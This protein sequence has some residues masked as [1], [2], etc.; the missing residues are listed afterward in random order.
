MKRWTIVVVIGLMAITQ[1]GSSLS[2]Q[3]P[4]R[5]F[6]VLLCVAEKAGDGPGNSQVSISIN[7]DTGPGADGIGQAE[8]TITG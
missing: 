1:V 7:S 2:Q 6:S 4:G 5:G 3:I 8:I